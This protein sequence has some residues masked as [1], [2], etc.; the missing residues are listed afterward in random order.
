[1]ASVYTIE[2][3]V[4]VNITLGDRPIAQSNFSTIPCCSL[5]VNACA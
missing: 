1:M 4:D 2:D 3:I 5:V